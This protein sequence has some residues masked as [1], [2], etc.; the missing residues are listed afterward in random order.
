MKAAEIR[1]RRF[2]RRQT[3]VLSSD[4]KYRGFLRQW[5]ESAV[6]RGSLQRMPRFNQLTEVLRT[7]GGFD[8]VESVI[9]SLDKLSHNLA[10]T[11]FASWKGRR[12]RLAGRLPFRLLCCGRIRFRNTTGRF[13]RHS[14][15]RDFGQRGDQVVKNQLAWSGRRRNRS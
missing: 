1:K 14:R 4:F 2:R 6:A 3:L 12:N 15:S 5:A 9:K 10:K 8:R 7:E 11:L 13:D